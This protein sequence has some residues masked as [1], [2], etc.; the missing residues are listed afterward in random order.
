MAERTETSCQIINER[1]LTVSQTAYLEIESLCQ[2]KGIEDLTRIAKLS[3]TRFVLSLSHLG[4]ALDLDYAAEGHGRLYWL[5]K[6]IKERQSHPDS[7]NIGDTGFVLT[8][9]QTCLAWRFLK[10]YCLIK[11]FP[12][13]PEEQQPI[14]DAL[15]SNMQ[16]THDLVLI[17][18]NQLPY[19]FTNVQDDLL[20]LARG[21]IRHL[22]HDPNFDLDIPYFRGQKRPK[23]W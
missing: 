4:P 8:V 13:L 6:I 15:K 21:R 5:I 12:L 16:C 19:D 1:W 11:N 14:L 2:N 18:Q 7:Q 22:I 17:Y 3:S 10:S 20:D 23:R 9:A